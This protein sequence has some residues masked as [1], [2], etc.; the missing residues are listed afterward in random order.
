VSSF[1]YSYLGKSEEKSEISEYI[2]EFY[3][4]VVR[5]KHF[6]QLSPFMFE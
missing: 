6:A 4:T 3:K 2:E 1:K 5:H